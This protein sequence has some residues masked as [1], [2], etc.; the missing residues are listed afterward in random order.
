MALKFTCETLQ[1]R[2][3]P[4]KSRP[5]TTHRGCALDP[6]RLLTHLVEGCDKVQQSRDSAFTN[7]VGPDVG[8]TRKKSSHRRFNVRQK[9]CLD[10]AEEFSDGVGS[11]FFLDSQRCAGFEQCFFI[12]RVDVLVHVF[13]IAVIIVI[14]VDT[15]REIVGIR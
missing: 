3:L 10:I 2:F 14:V 5:K 4:E 1:M 8:E 11:T 13:E 6:L 9:W 15:G 7:T 12:V